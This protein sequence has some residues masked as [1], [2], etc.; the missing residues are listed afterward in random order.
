MLNPKFKLIMRFFKNL[1]IITLLFTFFN[2][3]TEEI[4]NEN[5]SNSFSTERTIEVSPCLEFNLIAAQ[6]IVVGTVSVYHDKTN[7]IIRYET[8][9]DW[10]IEETHLSVGNN[11]EASFSTTGSGNPKI[12]KFEYSSSHDELVNVVDFYISKESI[13]EIY[14]FAAH[15]VVVDSNGTN[16]TA[17]AEGENFS[18]S[19]WAMFVEARLSAC[20]AVAG[21]GGVD[22]IK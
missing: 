5:E 11:G 19:N 2:C 14:Y 15:A 12:G 21:Y 22:P 17:W 6:N 10:G 4:F 16:E 20:D 8:I 7:I 13:N 9:E 3:N 18:G 1:F